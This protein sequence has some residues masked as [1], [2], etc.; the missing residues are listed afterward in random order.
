MEVN[1]VSVGAAALVTA[2]AT[3]LGALPFAVFPHVRS[4]RLALASAAAAGFML[5]AAVGLA[6]EGRHHGMAPVAVGAA[7][8]VAVVA[9]AGRF[10]RGSDDLHVGVLAGADARKLVAVVGIMTVHSVAEGVGVGVAYGGG[11]TLGALIT[12]AIA[13]HNIPEGLAISVVLVPRGAS[14]ATAAWWSVFS[15]APQ[16]LLAVPAFLFVEHFL[17]VLPYGLGF[18]AGAMVW[19]VARELLPDARAGAS[20]GAVAACVA[21]A[22][23][24]MTA[25]QA[26]VLGL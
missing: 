14:V 25:F 24:V 21:G 22:F 20:R 1:A 5:A 23:A 9:A 2:L 10:L 19:M 12:A 17:A 15:S 18:A 4:E 26:V 13:V 11:D 6:L 7:A 16:P 8:G 3:G